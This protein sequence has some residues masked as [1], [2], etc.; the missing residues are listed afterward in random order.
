MLRLNQGLRLFDALYLIPM[1]QVSWIFFSTISGGIYYE[2]FD[3]WGSTEV[4]AY[5]VGF[6]LVLIGVAMLCPKEK[7]DRAIPSEVFY[8]LV[9]QDKVKRPNNIQPSLVKPPVPPNK[10]LTTSSQQP[11]TPTSIP[12]PT[13]TK[14]NHT[15]QTNSAHHY[16]TLSSC[17]SGSGRHHRW[18]RTRRRLLGT[19]RLFPPLKKGR[20]LKSHVVH[21]HNR[22]AGRHFHPID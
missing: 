9:D 8:E 22:C 13:P 12:P 7:K 17:T 21:S 11:K 5:T 2:E 16:L 10:K 14:K 1:M 15:A 3:D 20:N 6:L 18:R 19:K 4:I